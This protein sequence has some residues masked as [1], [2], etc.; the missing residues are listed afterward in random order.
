MGRQFF[1]LLLTYLIFRASLDAGYIL[2]VNRHFEYSG[3]ILGL[4][5]LNYAI[6]WL[7]FLAS[8]IFCSVKGRNVS[9]YIYSVAIVTV[10]G[11]ITSYYGMTEGHILPVALSIL[12]VALMFILSKASFVKVPVAV[13]INEGTKVVI[14]ISAFSVLYLTVWYFYSGAVKN[15]NLNPSLVYEYREESR[16]LT[17]T[18]VLAY[19]N[20]WVYQVFLLFLFSYSLL[21]KNFKWMLFLFLVQAFFYGVTGH[22]SLILYPLMI[23]GIYFGTQYSRKTI[24]IPAISTMS[25]LLPLGWYFISSDILLGSMF[26]RRVYFLPAQLTYQYIEFFSN[27]EFVFWSNSV[28]ASF[29]DYPYDIGLGDLIGRSMGTEMNANNGFVASGYAHAGLF[30]VL[31]YSVLLGL[32]IRVI[33]VWSKPLPIWFALAL[34]IIPLRNALTASDLLT[35]ILT[36]G[37]FLAMMILLVMR[38]KF[39]QI[40][41]TPR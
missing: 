27:N 11:P 37:L 8:T 38:S 18:G 14:V 9:D 30:G 7:A 13:R 24:F 23:L 26:I 15:F 41:K 31:V 16:L 33:D 35:V 3:F 21:I 1:Y 19:I 12:A 4:E 25:I 40:A 2:F 6:S 20:S 17:S 39:I 10:I 36:H 5:F 28:L 32:L 22:K 34:V 29:I